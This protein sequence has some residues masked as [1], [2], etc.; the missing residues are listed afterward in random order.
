M[1]SVVTK[2]CLCFENL[3]CEMAAV[4]T[5]TFLET[6]SKVSHNTPLSCV[7]DP[8]CCV[9]DGFLQRVDVSSTGF[10]NF[11]VHV[12]TDR[13]TTGFKSGDSEGHSMTP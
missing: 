5:N 8:N 10:K 2:E 4:A 6:L 1:H 3:V 11:T 9:P 13:G 7:S 12:A